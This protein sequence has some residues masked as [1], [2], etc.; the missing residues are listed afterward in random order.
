MSVKAPWSQIILLDCY[1]KNQML[2]KLGINL[3]AA[4]QAYMGSTIVMG[5]EADLAA[6]T[7]H[8]LSSPVSMVSIRHDLRLGVALR[9]TLSFVRH[10]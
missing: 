1:H 2:M 6:R 3:L 4:K 9:F 7:V 5:S 10:L 8:K